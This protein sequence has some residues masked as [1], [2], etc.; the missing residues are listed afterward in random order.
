MGQGLGQRRTAKA[1]RSKE[2]S[3]M[4]KPCKSHGFARLCDVLTKKMQKKMG[5][6]KGWMNW[7]YFSEGQISSF[8]YFIPQF[9]SVQLSSVVTFPQIV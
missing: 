9:C 2:F 4:K 3:K 7:H 8:V 5:E 1:N 6:F